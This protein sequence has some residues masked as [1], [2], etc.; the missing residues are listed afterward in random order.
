M[1]KLPFV[2]LLLTGLAG[3]ATG[4][5]PTGA[6]YGNF[7]RN[8][9]PAHDQK[10]ANDAVK[11]LIAMYPPARTRFDLQQATPDV[12]G[13][14]LAESLR[15]RGYALLEFRPASHRTAASTPGPAAPA[16]TLAPSLP[17]RYI[18]DLDSDSNLYRITLLVGNQSLTRAY[19]AQNGALYPA[20]SWVRMEQ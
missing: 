20:G 9:P 13:T 16:A 7:I 6:Q 2:A 18:L 1:R 3:C 15:A 5:T 10:M 19:L 8:P 12:F 4:N 11:L 17:L 14:T